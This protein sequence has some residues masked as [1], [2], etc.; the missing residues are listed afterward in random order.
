MRI[1]IGALL[2]SAAL[3]AG[4]GKPAPKTYKVLNDVQQEVLKLYKVKPEPERYS[5]LK[6][7]LGSPHEMKGDTAIWY[8]IDDES[9]KH[10][11]CSLEV[12][13]TNGPGSM[14][15]LLTCEAAA[16]KCGMK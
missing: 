4:C 5:I 12:S 7:R 1:I 14:G 2:V 15:F 3:V 8:G 16:E 6:S 11:C 13:S 10:R 9:T